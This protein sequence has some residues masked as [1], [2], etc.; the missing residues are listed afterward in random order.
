MEKERKERNRMEVRESEIR[1][2]GS[3]RKKRCGRDGEQIQPI[4]RVHVVVVRHDL[5]NGKEG[6]FF[7]ISLKP[8]M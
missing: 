7:L 2:E 4:I 8:K 6:V 5:V 1:R 3:E